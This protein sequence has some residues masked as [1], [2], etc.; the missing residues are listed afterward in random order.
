MMS[1]QKFDLKAYVTANFVLWYIVPL[2]LMII[3]YTKISIVLW[4]SSQ[5]GLVGGST[6]TRVKQR[7]P[8]GIR[9]IR[10]KSFTSRTHSSTSNG[11]H[12]GLPASSSD[13]AVGEDYHELNTNDAEL[14]QTKKS[15]LSEYKG[16]ISDL[17]DSFDALDDPEDYEDDWPGKTPRMHLHQIKQK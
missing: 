10:L 17:G 8:S 9:S 3:M 2:V 5:A 6:Q 12:S 4:K 7:S 11:V 14:A 13:E 15:L 16:P 1:N